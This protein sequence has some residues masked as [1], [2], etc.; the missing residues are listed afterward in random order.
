MYQQIT[1][2]GNVGRNPEL[3]YTQSGVAVCDFSVAVNKVI[4][5]GESRR[6][7]T[8][9]FRVTCWRQL[10]EVVNQ[11]LTRGRQVLVIGEVAVSAYQDRSGQPAA[12][13]EVTAREVK[14]LGNRSDGEGGGDGGGYSRNF[15]EDFAPPPN[16]VDDIPF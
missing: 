3:R 4:G 12:S 2:V 15:D 14:F 7:Q 13:L 6:E 8:T 10:A 1:I 16:Q 5:S 9:W 11:Y